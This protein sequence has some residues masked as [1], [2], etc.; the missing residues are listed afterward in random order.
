MCSKLCVVN[1]VGES[2]HAIVITAK[3][4]NEKRHQDKG[5]S[6]VFQSYFRKKIGKFLHFLECPKIVQN[7]LKN[8]FE[9]VKFL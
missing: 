1:C 4:R 5:K 9:K 3:N 6:Y 2:T 8:P 7:F